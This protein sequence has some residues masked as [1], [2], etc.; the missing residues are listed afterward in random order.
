MM[1][2]S[3][4]LFRR[5]G[6]RRVAA[7]T[8][9]FMLAAGAFQAL[10]QACWA[11]STCMWTPGTCHAAGLPL[12]LHTSG[13][14][15]PSSGNT[16]GRLQSTCCLAQQAAR[17]AGLPFFAGCVLFALVPPSQQSRLLLLSALVYAGALLQV[18]PPGPKS[19]EGSGSR[20]WRWYQAL[21]SAAA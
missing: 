16:C 20:V 21:S 14:G 1:F 9:E 3:P 12:G 5:W 10:P 13:A 17:A 6:W 7:L 4:V 18:G 19:L 2:L 8:P 11:S 15:L